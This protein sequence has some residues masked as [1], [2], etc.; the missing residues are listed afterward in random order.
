MKIEL[1]QISNTDFAKILKWKSDPALSIQIM[2]KC[3]VLNEFETI[4]WIIKNSSDPNQKLNGIYLTSNLKTELIGITR[5][6]FIN[7]ESRIG[8]LGIYLGENQYQGLGIGTNALSLTIKQAFE[9]LKLNKLYLRVNS[10]NLKAINL[11]KKF[12][13]QIEGILKKH[14]YN[15]DMN[16]F[17]DITYMS[18]FNTVEI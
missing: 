10:N 11:Y 2:S 12:N 1:K 14:Y 17:D 18:L 5:I 4:Q 16:V 3:I 6:M 13:F 15:Q 7:F 9:E 8:E